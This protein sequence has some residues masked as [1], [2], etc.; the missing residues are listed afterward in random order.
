RDTQRAGQPGALEACERAGQALGIAL[1]SAIHLM[2]P[3]MIVLGGV[4]APLFPW[5]RDPVNQAM[6]ARL[7]GMR[8]TVPELTVS[9]LG[10]DAAPLGAAGQIIHRIIANPI[11]ILLRR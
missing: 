1:T 11:A 7:T 10:S 2:D 3:G 4:F 8:H 9:R 5:I 6:T